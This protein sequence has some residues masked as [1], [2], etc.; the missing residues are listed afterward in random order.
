MEKSIIMK[1]ILGVASFN[2][3]LHYDEDEEIKTKF[4]YKNGEL[5]YIKT[6]IGEEEELLEIEYSDSIDESYLEIPSYYAES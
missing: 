2:Q 5:K 4:Y 1:N 6:I 3:L